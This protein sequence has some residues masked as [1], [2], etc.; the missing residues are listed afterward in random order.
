MQFWGDIIL[1]KPELIPE[2]PKDMIALNWG[3]ESDHPFE[4]ETRAFANAGVPFYVCPGTSSW[5]SIAGRTQNAMENLR[6]SAA[7]GLAHG[8]SGY[9]NTDWGDLGHLQYL[10][11]SL[12]G[13]AAGAA[14]SWC[15]ESNRDIDLISALDTHIF[16][17]S[18]QVMGR[19]V[20]DFGNVYRAATTP[21][22]NASR[23]FWSLLDDPQRA[24]NWECLTR[25]EFDDAEARA[26]DILA[27]LDRARMNRSDAGL[28]TS[29]IR[30]AAAMLLYACR[31]GRWRMHQESVSA[32]EL[33]AQRESIVAEHRRLWLARNRSGGLDDSCRRL[34]RPITR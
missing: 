6:N 30:N 31:H 18:A 23:F 10:P 20:S 2:L 26:S 11:V 25:E 3:Y 12:L 5:C 22:P 1:H 27:G 4:K 9:L 28:I 13:F 16:Q 32:D 7:C 34:S 24:K 19:L 17:D 21:V 33:R 15:L 29:E 14:Y 8:A